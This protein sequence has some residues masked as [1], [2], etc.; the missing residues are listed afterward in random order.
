MTFNGSNPEGKLYAQ[1]FKEPI[2]VTTYTM[3]Q[4]LDSNEIKSNIECIVTFLNSDVIS[5]FMLL[6]QYSP[7]PRNK[8]D[9]KLLNMIQI[10]ELP[11]NCKVEDIYN[12]YN[13]TSQEIK[14]LSQVVS[15]T[16]TSKKTKKKGRFVNNNELTKKI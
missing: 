10:P 2:G 6:T 15:Y 14:L 12:Y 13:L 8:N 1:Y 7:A 3:Y 5:I 16:K 4:L 9:W 11:K